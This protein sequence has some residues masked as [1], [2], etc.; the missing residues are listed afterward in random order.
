MV[1]SSVPRA[2]NPVLHAIRVLQIVKHV[3]M[4]LV[5]CTSNIK[6][7]ACKHALMVTS[8]R[9]KQ[10]GVRH[11]IQLVQLALIL[12]DLVVIVVEQ[13]TQLLII[14]HLV[15]QNALV[16]VLMVNLRT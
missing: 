11:V 13:P 8:E 14:C 10:I 9:S 7:N 2:M 4:L 12:I 6:M 3:K 16:S 15:L 1:V 5:M